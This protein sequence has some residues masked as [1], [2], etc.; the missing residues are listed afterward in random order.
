M[1]KTLLT[2]AVLV[3]LAS[4]KKNS[5]EI[6]EPIKPLSPDI[7]LAVTGATKETEAI[8][9]SSTLYN[10][11]G[12]GYDATENFNSES[13]IRAN[14][15]DMPGFDADPLHTV[16]LN[17]GTKSSWTTIVAK[18]A[19]DLSEKFS[20]SHKETK[21]LRLFA[22]TLIEA[23]PGAA[24]TDKKYIYGYYSFYMIRKTLRFYYDQSVNNFLSNQF[25]QDVNLL[26]AEN[27]I[28]KYGTHILIGLNVGAKFDVIYQAEALGE[29]KEEISNEGF[30]YALKRAFGLFSGSLDDVKLIN[31]HKNSSAK[32]YYS[33]IGGDI[34][35]LET[36]KINDRTFLNISNWVS[37]TTEDKARFMGV[38][39]EGL[40]PIYNFIDD[41]VKKAEVK[42]YLEQYF[43]V[44][45][46]KLTN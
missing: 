37:T 43:A 36:Q 3:L 6:I 16:S 38:L 22:N 42:A 29:N 41:K 14:V 32:V 7:P 39:N 35:K 34:R 21:G 46:M 26:N 45:A 15:V 44:K 18:N 24:V 40:V 1:K 8:Y 5:D 11:L 27:L 12:Y 30:N 23:F 10:Y 28:K 2:L 33:S 31:L 20:N 4:C 13:S 17:L 9:P 25:K 19:V